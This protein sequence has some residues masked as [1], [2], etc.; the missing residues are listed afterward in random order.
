MPSFRG[1]TRSSCLLG[2]LLLIG[3]A[4]FP[5]DG[6]SQTASH[7]V[8]INRHALP[9]DTLALLERTFGAR[10]PD[11]RYWYDPVSGAWGQE[12]AGTLGFT[13]AGLPVGG[14]LP[15]NISGG[16]TRVFI[17]GREL[18]PADLA[19]LQQLTGPIA[20]GRYW[21]DPQGNAGMEG[22]PPLVNL[23]ALAAQAG[24]YRQN[25]GVGENYGGGAGAYGN[26]R[27]GIGII[28]DGQGGAAVFGP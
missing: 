26:L 10:I 23:R 17:N 13:I 27:T 3:G 9:A 19:G 14:P 25:G 4:M 2:S 5:S 7:Q 21:L 1:F 18:P 8:F 20:L 12:G 16:G 22:G 24:L 28:T 6:V 11:G 15:A